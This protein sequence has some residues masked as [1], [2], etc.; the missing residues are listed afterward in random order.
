MIKQIPLMKRTGGVRVERRADMTE[1]L[2]PEHFRPHL[3]KLFRVQ[4]GRH[5]LRL[6]EMKVQPLTEEQKA[7]APRQPFNL[8]FHGPPSDVLR[9]GLYVFDVDNG[10]ATFE[11]YVM[12]IQTFV[13]DRQD[14]QAVFN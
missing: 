3:E 12:P 5:G 4:G 7:M 6:A 11:L 9:E 2:T 14:Y 10:G 13:R 1:Q 8:I